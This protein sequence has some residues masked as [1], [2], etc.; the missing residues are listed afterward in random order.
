MTEAVLKNENNIS[1]RIERIPVTSVHW[2]LWL[3]HE[4][5]WILGSIG[6][7]T[8][9]FTLASI[10]AEFGMGSTVKGLVAS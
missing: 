4:I 3:M 6:L 5:C 9:T 1:G 10:A 2:R 8:G 7:A